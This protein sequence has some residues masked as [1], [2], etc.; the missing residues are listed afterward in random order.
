MDLT[1]EEHVWQAK[2][3]MPIPRIFFNL[4]SRGDGYVY[5]FGGENH[6]CWY[7]WHRS[8]DRVDRYEIATNTWTGPVVSINIPITILSH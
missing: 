4:L 5:A 8:K 2:A 3:N 7:C 6:N 1:K